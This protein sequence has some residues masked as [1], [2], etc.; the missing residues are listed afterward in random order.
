MEFRVYLNRIG[1]PDRFSGRCFLGIIAVAACTSPHDRFQAEKRQ[2]EACPTKKRL[3]L[4]EAG[5]TSRGKL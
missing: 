4:S 1:R 3:T 5:G 2:A